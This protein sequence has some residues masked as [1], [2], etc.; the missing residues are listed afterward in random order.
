MRINRKYCP[1][2]GSKITRKKIEDRLRDYCKDCQT[3]FYDNPL[4]VVSAVVPNKYREILLVLRDREP[5]AGKWCLPSGFV[6]LNETVE[7][8]V[9]REL[10]EETGISGKVLRLT[11]TYSRYNSIYGDLIWVF[12]DSLRLQRLLILL[13][14]KK[15]PSQVFS[16]TCKPLMHNI[17][18]TVWLAA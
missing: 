13:H 10:K 6:E 9:I 7:K 5:Y 1:K 17:C 18:L 11:D 16:P 2:C 8:G 14:S 4:P 12:K 15:Q 3:V